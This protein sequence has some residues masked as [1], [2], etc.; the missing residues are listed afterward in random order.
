[1]DEDKLC[2][3]VTIDVRPDGRKELVALADAYRESAESWADLLRDCACRGMRAPVLAIGNGA[4]G[5][6]K[7]AREAAGGWSTRRTWSR[8]SAPK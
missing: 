2:Q 7:A 5:F 4:L 6:W 8:S 1:M 3:L